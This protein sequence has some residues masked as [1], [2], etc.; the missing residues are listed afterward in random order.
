MSKLMESRK[1]APKAEVGMAGGLAGGAASATTAVG[2]PFGS[3]PAHGSA[4]CP[5]RSAQHMHLVQFYLDQQRHRE[6]YGL[7]SPAFLKRL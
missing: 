3:Q 2:S 5:Q 4:T 1:R 7:C 6:V